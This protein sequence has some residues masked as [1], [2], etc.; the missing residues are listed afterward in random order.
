[1]QFLVHA[2]GA[3]LVTLPKD[4]LRLIASFVPI[5]DWARGPSRVCR[6]LNKLELPENTELHIRSVHVPAV[7]NLLL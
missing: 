6:H 7:V 2:T 1:M 4:V 3:D 5:K